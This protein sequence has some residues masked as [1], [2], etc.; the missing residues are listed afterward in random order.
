MKD[1]LMDI[2]TIAE[3][4]EID[5]KSGG[6]ERRRGAE[7]GRKGRAVHV[8]KSKRKGVTQLVEKKSRFTTG[9]KSSVG[10]NKFPD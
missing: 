4:A 9:S 6:E 10:S 2:R 8:Q 5:L 1:R 7:E 3:M